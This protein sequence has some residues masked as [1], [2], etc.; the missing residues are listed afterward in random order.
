MQEKTLG[1]LAEYV[2]G[3]VSGD[4]KVIIRSASTL[5]RAVKV[6]SVFWQTASMKSS[7]GQQKQARLL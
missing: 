7:F 3:R 2:G 1:E 5:G 6:K 4:P